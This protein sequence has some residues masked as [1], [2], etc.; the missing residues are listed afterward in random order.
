MFGLRISLSGDPKVAAARQKLED[1]LAAEKMADKA[2]ADAKKKVRAA[3][4]QA[5]N[6]EREA[7]E[8]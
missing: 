6:L 5:K 7:L 8:E 2:L 3:K 1:A 4:E